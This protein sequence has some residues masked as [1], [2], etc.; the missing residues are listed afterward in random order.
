V[1]DSTPSRWPHRHLLDTDQ[2][3]RAEAA[4]CLDRAAA[5]RD[6]SDDALAGRI[7]GLAFAEA[8]TRTRVSFEVA[9]RARGAASRRVHRAG[10]DRGGA[11]RG[12]ERRCDGLGR[13]RGL[14]RRT[15]SAS[16]KAAAK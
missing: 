4:A 7:I 1:T 13:D 6:T 11:R 12:A 15:G 9:A 8:S 3:T 2:L 14:V 16:A 10:R 5:L